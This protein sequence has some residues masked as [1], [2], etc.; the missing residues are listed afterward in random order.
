MEVPHKHTVKACTS[1]CIV[2]VD[3]NL[4]EGGIRRV[5]TLSSVRKAK[6]LV[7]NIGLWRGILVK[8]KGLPNGSHKKF[9]PF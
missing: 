3:I 1:I 9:R 6:L 2:K 8:E 7:K 4:S 5:F